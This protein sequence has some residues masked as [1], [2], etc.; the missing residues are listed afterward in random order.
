MSQKSSL[1]S[2]RSFCLTVLTADTSLTRSSSIR[3]TLLSAVPLLSS[4]MVAPYL[5]LG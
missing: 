1:A 3:I 4:S 2:T 5:W